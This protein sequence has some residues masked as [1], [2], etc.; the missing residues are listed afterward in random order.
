MITF[1]TQA[2]P[3]FFFCSFTLNG[4]ESSVRTTAKKVFD[5]LCVLNKRTPRFDWY[6]IITNISNRLHSAHAQPNLTYIAF[7]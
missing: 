1:D 5:V 7:C 6:S 3:F 2:I 4:L